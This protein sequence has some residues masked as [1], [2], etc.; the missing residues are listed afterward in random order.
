MGVLKI[1]GHV[2]Q[3]PREVALEEIRALMGDCRRCPLGQ[4]KTNLVFGVGSPQAR[5]M[6]VGEGPGRNEDLQGEPFV[7]AAGHNLDALLECAGLKRS[8]V[9]IANVLKC[10]PPNNRNP[11]PEE[12]AACA[13]FLREQI[14]SVWPDMI[15][16]LGN[17]ATQFVLHTD[18]G[19]TKLRGKIYE[20]GHF[21]VVP[22][23]HPAAA[24]Y[25]A[26]WQPL[27]EADIRLVGEWLQANPLAGEGE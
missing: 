11:K 1:P 22:T 6:F 2:H 4:T 13:P 17:F 23:F 12:I 10:R 5:V 14:R 27:L 18:S 24:L 16:C 15:V 3:K 9:Y 7:G 21:K 19:V 25:H 26:E 20:V 8:E